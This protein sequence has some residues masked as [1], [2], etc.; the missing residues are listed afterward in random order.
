MLMDSR[1][2]GA[3]ASSSS[4]GANGLWKKLWGLAIPNVEKNFLW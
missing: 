3:V 4:R 2:L 1:V